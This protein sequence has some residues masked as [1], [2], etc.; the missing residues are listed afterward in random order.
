MWKNVAYKG[1]KSTLFLAGGADSFQQHFFVGDVKL[2]GNF[3]R[4]FEAVECRT[5][6]IDNFAASG[7]AYVVV[8]TGVG[9][10]ALG[11]TAAFHDFQQADVC[12]C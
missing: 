1:A 10:E 11:I 12:K 6:E 5:G 8:R 4:N 7:A 2:A 3:R 9:I